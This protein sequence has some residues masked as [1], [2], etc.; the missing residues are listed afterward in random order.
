[1]AEKMR[2]PLAVFTFR[3]PP[4]NY[5]LPNA[6]PLLTNEEEKKVQIEALGAD[7]LYSIPFEASIASMPAED[8]FARLLVEQLGAAALVCGFNYNFGKGGLGNTEL[9]SRLCKE[10]GLSLTVTPPIL[11]EGSPVSSSRIREAIAEGNVTA[12][13]HMLGRPYAICAEV[14]NGQRLARQLGFPT[15]NQ[16]L[17]E[18]MAIPRYGV[19]LSRV[20]QIEKGYGITNVGMR[21]TVG[22]SLLCAETH[23]FDF[24]GDLYGK[25]LT[26]E[27]LEFL[28]P[29]RPFPSVDALR[30][31]V[32]ADIREAR[33]LARG[34]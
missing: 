21:P 29:E 9:L 33:R 10:K 1:M 11:D 7:L 27:L 28:R 30:E 34:Q 15:L 6:V 32:E 13:R 17:S 2:L 31:Q 12:V 19:Y 16:P 26:V 24:S 4:K 8:F 22:G 25:T 20:R 23:I 18:K 14:I 5:F 3:E